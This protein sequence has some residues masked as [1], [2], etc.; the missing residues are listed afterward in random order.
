MKKKSK[1][2]V[3]NLKKSQ[4]EKAIRDELAKADSKRYSYGNRFL[5]NAF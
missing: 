3:E 5:Y 4:Q 2:K 1:V